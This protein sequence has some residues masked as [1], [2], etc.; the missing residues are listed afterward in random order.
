MDS[1]SARQVVKAIKLE[2]DV[3]FIVDYLFQSPAQCRCP[4]ARRFG[5]GPVGNGCANLSQAG[6]MPI[7]RGFIEI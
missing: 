4:F 5:Q 3:L 2:D 6:E 7:S 1:R